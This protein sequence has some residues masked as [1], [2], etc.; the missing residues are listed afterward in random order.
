MIQL[1]EWETGIRKPGEISLA[2]PENWKDE[3][4]I[5]EF[6]NATKTEKLETLQKVSVSILSHYNMLRSSIIFSLGNP[7]EYNSSPT[8]S[9]R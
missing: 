8:F 7:I 2:H 9:R 5:K 1:M 3:T 4:G 6:L